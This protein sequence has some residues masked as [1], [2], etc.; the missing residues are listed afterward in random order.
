M[1]LWLAPYLAAGYRRGAQGPQHFDCWGLVRELQRTRWGRSMPALEVGPAV[2]AQ[3][4]NA[5]WQALAQLCRRSGWHLRPAGQPP[6]A[7]DVLLM[8]GAGG[9]HVGVALDALRMVHAHGGPSPGLEADV[10]HD[11]GSVS[12]ARLDALGLLG[13]VLLSVW[14]HEGAAEDAAA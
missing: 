9:L 4:G 10:R 14:A 12:V 13:L 6:A 2:V 5:Q 8:R 3:P 1:S 7:G 11:R